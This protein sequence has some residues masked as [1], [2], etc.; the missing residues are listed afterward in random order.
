MNGSGS[1]FAWS[2]AASLIFLLLA[3]HVVLAALHLFELAGHEA[4]DE[5]AQ[6]PAADEEVDR[7]ADVERAGEIGARKRVDELGD[8]VRERHAAENYADDQCRHDDAPRGA[9]VRLLWAHFFT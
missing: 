8:L 1:A 2:D 3:Q 9:V 6:P 4:P 7:D 5:Q